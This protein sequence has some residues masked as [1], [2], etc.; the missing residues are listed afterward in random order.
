VSRSK[1]HRKA[2]T[3]QVE[4][5]PSAED[6]EHESLLKIYQAPVNVKLDLSFLRLRRNAQS[7]PRRRR[8]IEYRDQNRTMEFEEFK[9]KG[10]TRNA[11]RFV[12][13]DLLP[14]KRTTSD[15][16]DA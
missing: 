12:R 9:K 10:F 1:E 3:P 11:R 8:A 15:K 6:P 2:W 14:S 5:F 13:K 16:P 4:E 7:I